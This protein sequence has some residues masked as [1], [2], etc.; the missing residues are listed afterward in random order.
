MII[1]AGEK[2]IEWGAFFQIEDRSELERMVVKI[3]YK[4]LNLLETSRTAKDG[5][6]KIQLLAIY[7]NYK[8]MI[9]KEE[10]EMSNKDSLRL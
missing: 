3:L 6:S 5:E 8:L 2:F 10:K 7:S 4:N 1:A 9:D